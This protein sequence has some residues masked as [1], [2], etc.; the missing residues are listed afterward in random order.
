MENNQET[1]NGYVDHIIYRNTDN[2]YTVLVLICDEEELTCV[3]TF[4]DIAEGENIE[5]RGVFTDH[6]TYGRQFKV[7]SFEEKAPQDVVA[8]ER[9][10]GS[11]AIKGVGIALA[12]R[13]VRRF[14]E[15]T[16]RIIE[17]EPERLAEIK[18]ISE[19]KAMEIA[20]Q[21]NAKRDLRQAMIF[22][23]QY[24]ISTTLA[25]KIYNQYGQEVYG[26]LQENPYRMAD[27]IEGVGFRTADE[28]ASR[29]GIRTDSDFRI[30]SGIQYALL[31]ASGEGHTY[32][33]MEEL[34]GRASQLLGLEPEYIE[35][36]YMN[37]AMD[38]K[39]IMRQ[40]DGVTQM[41]SSAFFYMEANTATMLK[42]LDVSYDVPDIEIE[43]R[44][45]QIEKQTKMDLDEHQVEAV[46][47]AVRNGLL[48][49]TG[50]PG[51]GKTT[52]INTIIRYFEMEGMDIFLAAPT[53]RAAK[54]MSETTGFEARTI[55]RM[56]ELNGGMEGNAGFERNEQNPLETDVII[57]DEMSMVDISL[58]YALLKAV[59]AGTRLILVG[60][61][62]QLPSVGPGS[63]LKDII[64]S[65][66]FHT[67]KL[68]KI[69]RQAST[70]DIIV[71]AHKINRGEPVSLDNKSMDFFFLKRYD[72]DKII[73]VTLQ[74]IKQKLP[75][76]VGASEYDIQ[77]LTPM[78]K[79][80]LG[81]ERLNTVLQMYLN[82]P[83]ASKREKEYGS[84]LFR[85]GDKVMQVKNNYQ[86]EWEIRSKYG[87]MI[88]KGTG[89]F[90]GDMG[91]IEEINDFAETMTIS[92]DEGR[93]V[94]YPYKLLEELELAYA[95]TIHK[96][97]GSEYPA[98]VIPLLTGPRMLM[99]RNLLYTAVTR[100]KKC[101]TIV[102]ND[103]TFQMMIENNAEQRRYSGLKDRLTEE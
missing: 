39:I 70:S 3:G 46:K 78:R 101:V 77:V 69:F 22:L 23:Q 33:P 20:D 74:L 50:G 51:T 5:A 94:E 75:K 38:R 34:T 99:N 83:D 24:G 6:P 58:M 11:G 82:P 61:V 27:D 60:D 91:I 66:M 45:R 100:A 47:E 26:I 13:I 85:E 8:I 68:T 37:L 28:I 71:N 52:T 87:L 10:L 7:Q 93:M 2:G 90:N 79:G 81:V 43:M 92:F 56:L 54:R 18:G 32:L 4:S 31:Q 64:D 89:I 40:V 25:V 96:S 42:Q 102:G 55:H 80:L 95:I 1:I 17:E 41:Y 103:E 88:D 9:Y 21:V 57:I 14:K 63:V 72:A 53:G 12:A 35:N 97:Q 65:G 30:R 19:R 49:I 44:L 84:T 76:F 73:N 59:V 86:L 36:H 67:V 16:F 15:D 29:V 98:V 48:I 62:N